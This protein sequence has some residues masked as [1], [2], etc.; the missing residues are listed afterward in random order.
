M[1]GA[2]RVEGRPFASGRP[3]CDLGHVWN[4]A[5]L[6]CLYY[7]HVRPHLAHGKGPP[8][9]QRDEG[10]LTN[11]QLFNRRYLMALLG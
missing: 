7:N 6:L 5:A 10:Q 4:W 9:T 1:Q 8:L 2:F 3:R 11:R